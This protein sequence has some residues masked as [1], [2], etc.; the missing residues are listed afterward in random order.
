MHNSTEDL[1]DIIYSSKDYQ[2]E[3][4]QI[5][6][7]INARFSGTKTILDVACGTGKHAEYLN[8]SF[9]V[10]GIDISERFVEIA[11]RRNPTSSFWC[12]DMTSFELEKQYDIVMCLFSAVA[13]ANSFQSLTQALKQMGK[14]TKRSG[15]IIVEPWFTPEAWHSGYV[16]I[17]N[18]ESNDVKVSRMSFSD[19]VGNLSILTFEYLIGTREGITHVTEKHELGLFTVD[20]ML[21]A[22]KEAG[23]EAEYDPQGISGRGLYIAKA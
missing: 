4:A 20:E 14:H 9:T 10:D 13:Y 16:S 7:F 6:D 19:R 23:F 15:S 17:V 1:Y 5:S 22:F 3:A 8:R 11:Q 18:G 12:K 2:K 21:S